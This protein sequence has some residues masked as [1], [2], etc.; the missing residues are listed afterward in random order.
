[1]STA[2]K[3]LSDW[4]ARLD[5]AG[6]GPINDGAERVD[7]RDFDWS[8]RWR[9][10]HV[11]TTDEDGRAIM[12]LG[13]V[14]EATGETYVELDDFGRPLEV[15][16]DGV[17]LIEAI[18]SVWPDPMVD[19]ALVD[20]LRQLSREIRYFIF[21]RLVREGSPADRLFVALP[22]EEVEDAART[23]LSA[24]RDP[25]DRAVDADLRHWVTPAVAKVV[26]PLAQLCEGLATSDAELIR[27]GSSALCEG[28]AAANVRRMPAT[29][30]EA[31]QG[32]VNEIAD[33]NLFLRRVASLASES[34]SGRLGADDRTG[35]RLT[36]E[37]PLA[38]STEE[39]RYIVTREGDE[40]PMVLQTRLS[41][42][43][44]L[45]IIVMLAMDAG[46]DRD[47]LI[48]TYGEVFVPVHLSTDSASTTY[49]I[50][51]RERT[52]GLT[53]RVEVGLP[54]GTARLWTGPPA[55]TAE[56]AQLSIAELRRS[57]DAADNAGR[58]LWIATR[59]RLSAGHRL[60]SAIP[61]AR[62]DR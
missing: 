60:R 16:A 56:L 58:S 29:T 55:G 17:A 18:E 3:P 13:L 48:S 4:I 9:R 47:R 57:F 53:G 51:L 34:L 11:T 8:G 54:E 22:W 52:G 46:P 45:I 61:E 2:C 37:Q 26:G 30:V 15:S 32:L 62:D 39:T 10:E 24:L 20:R 7:A 35:T 36:S 59:D 49:W 33:Q 31:F 41:P 27:I 6:R 19:D 44:R 5:H 42:E 43:G 23:A 1:M 25:S 12:A 40:G 50:A 21:L 28:L 14:E 38:A